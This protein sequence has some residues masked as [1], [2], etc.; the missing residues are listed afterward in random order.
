MKGVSQIGLSDGGVGG[1]TIFQ[2]A[3]Q[4]KWGLLRVKRQIMFC[5]T[6]SE[7]KGCERYS[8]TERAGVLV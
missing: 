1:R 7:A 6:K 8:P 5:V 2:A 3:W 4:E